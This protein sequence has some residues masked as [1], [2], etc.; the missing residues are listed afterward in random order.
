MVLNIQH[1]SMNKLWGSNT[2]NFLSILKEKEAKNTRLHF[3]I[4]IVLKPHLRIIGQNW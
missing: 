1:G 3:C 4:A 2:L